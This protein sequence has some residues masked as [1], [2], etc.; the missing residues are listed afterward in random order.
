MATTETPSPAPA[1][2]GRTRS[3]LFASV[4]GLAGLVILLQAVWAGLFIREGADFKDNW[5]TVH[6]VGGT[7]SMVLALI[8]VIVAF[9]QLRARRDLVIGSVVFFLL[10]V[11]EGLLGGFIGDTPALETVHFPLALLL[12]AMTAW[13]SLRSRR[14]A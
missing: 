1:A 14:Q 4:I 12:M 6:S 3:P 8:A 5:V 2:T 11:V 7:V 9:V 13:L 10:L